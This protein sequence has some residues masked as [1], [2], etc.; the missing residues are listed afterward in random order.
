MIDPKAQV[1]YAQYNE[2]TILRVLLHDVKKG[3]YVDVGA[4]YPTIDSV[5]KNF[6][7]AGWSGINIEPLKS[8]HKQ[9]LSERPND[10]NLQ[11]GA[12]DETGEAVLR[13]YIDVSGHST[14]DAGQ[15]KQHGS[16][17]KHTDYTVP[18]RTLKDILTEYKPQHI[19]FFKIDVEGYEYQVVAGNDWELFRPEVICVEANHIS[20]DWRPLL[21][22]YKYRLFIADGLN[23][24]YLA[25]ESWGRTK[26]F[27]ERAVE[28]G[29]H[30]LKQHQ[31]QSWSNDSRDLERLDKLI[32]EERSQREIERKQTESIATLSLKEQP[33][34]KRLKRA[35]Y[36]L[37]V[38]WVR[39]KKKQ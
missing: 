19:H 3:F 35:A 13:E 17:L 20:R 4:N 10:I 12:G 5:T 37:T 14:F 6:Y 26:G 8:L 16:G 31:Y 34:I 18:I 36:G 9:L 29:Y 1:T 15:K 2:D 24:Y 22:K 25:E 21:Q 33:F 32:K 30:T 39:Y 7:D 28:L 27:A 11:I 38:D 23:E